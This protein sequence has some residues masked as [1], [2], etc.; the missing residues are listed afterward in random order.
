MSSLKAIEKKK[1][2]IARLED[3]F[4]LEKLKARK[5]DTRRKIEFG[6]LVIKSGM[7]DFSKDIILGAL[8]HVAA[9]IDKDPAQLK[10]YE[11]IG[12]GLFLETEKA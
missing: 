11:S 3:N 7:S 5:S 8:A 2:L 9:E 6:G 12:Q 10:V 4:A 1:Q